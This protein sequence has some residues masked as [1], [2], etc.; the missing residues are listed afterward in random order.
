M[1]ISSDLLGSILD[2]VNW[3]FVAGCLVVALLCSRMFGYRQRLHV[4]EAAHVSY[5]NLVDH[6]ADG[7]YRS[8]L[9]GKQLSANPALVKL[10]GYDSEAQMLV[11]VQDIAV[12]WYVEPG[13]REEFRAILARDGY[14]KDFISEI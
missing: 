12:E 8:S 3:P 5:R 1:Q 9:E 4:V 7:V 2:V 6:L 11:G 14:V 13:R 10:N